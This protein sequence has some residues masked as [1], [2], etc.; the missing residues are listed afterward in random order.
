MHACILGEEE[1]EDA[2]EGGGDGGHHEH[3]VGVWEKA[4]CIFISVA[5]PFSSPVLNMSVYL[6]NRFYIHTISI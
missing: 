5:F 4:R 3:L 6:E 2:G 1:E